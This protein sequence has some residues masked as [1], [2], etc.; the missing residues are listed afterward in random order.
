MAFIGL[1]SAILADRG[2][3][4]SEQAETLVNGY[5]IHLETAPPRRGDAKRSCRK[6]VFRTLQAEFKPYAPGVVEGNR[7]KKHGETDYRLE[8][9][10]TVKEFTQ[11]ILETIIFRNNFHVLII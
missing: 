4:L 2:E 1:P 11:I 10:L 9:V 3:M 6:V 7:I 8:A 5:N